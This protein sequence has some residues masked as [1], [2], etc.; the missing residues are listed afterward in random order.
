MG[1]RNRAETAQPA[2]EDR[3]FRINRSDLVAMVAEEEATH[4]RLLDENF[5]KARTE[6]MK[7]R[8]R[9]FETYCVVGAPTTLQEPLQELLAVNCQSPV[10]S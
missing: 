6:S 2:E 5:A 9:L 10:W 8:N 7:R 3:E 4:D 1:S